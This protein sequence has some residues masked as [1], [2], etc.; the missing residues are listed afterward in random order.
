M[1]FN[2]MNMV[3]IAI[4]FTLFNRQ[5]SFLNNFLFIFNWNT[6]LLKVSYFFYFI[7]FEFLCLNNNFRLFPDKSHCFLL[8]LQFVYF[9]FIVIL[10]YY[11]ILHLIKLLSLLSVFVLVHIFLFI[12][13][14]IQMLSYDVSWTI[15]A[16]W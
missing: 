11:S 3:C 9:L 15:Y 12:Q 4:N 8:I 5:F 14:Y 10:S 2:K 1:G 7:H 16:I 13:Q 6:A